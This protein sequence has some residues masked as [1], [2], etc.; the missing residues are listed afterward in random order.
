MA[1][2][3]NINAIEQATNIRWAEWKSWLDSRNACE[4]PHQEIAEIVCAKIEKIVDNPGWWSQGI[5]V[6]YE[7]EIGRRLPGQRS[8]GTFEMSVS[9]SVNEGRAQLFERCTQV[10]SIFRLLNDLEISNPRSSVTPVRSNWRCEFSDGSK[11]VWSV[12]VKTPEK[13]QLVI[14]QTNMK[15]TEEATLWKKFWTDFVEKNILHKHK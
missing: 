1:K 3:Q 13:S 14:R 4:L 8:D 7:Q 2:P 12:D 10:L 5:T 11:T 15:S 6:A 9:K